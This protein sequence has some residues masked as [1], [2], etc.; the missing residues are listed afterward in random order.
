MMVA[1]TTNRM[2]RVDR[3]RGPRARES[4]SNKIKSIIF[5]MTQLIRESANYSKRR[6]RRMENAR[7]KCNGENYDSQKL[8]SKC[9]LIVHRAQKVRMHGSEVTEREDQIPYA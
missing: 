9:T 2:R 7:C 3:K 6:Y 5:Q 4:S 1:V 8:M